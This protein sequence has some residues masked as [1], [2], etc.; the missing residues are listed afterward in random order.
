MILVL[1]VG[2]LLGFAV[3]LTL[4]FVSPSRHHT[5]GHDQ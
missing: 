4:A 5:G 1:A 2:A 3:V